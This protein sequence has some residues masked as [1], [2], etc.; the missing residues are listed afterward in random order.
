LCVFQPAFLGASAPAHGL[1]LL[2]KSGGK[3][4]MEISKA[5]MLG[6]MDVAM[7]DPV[8]TDANIRGLAE[9]IVKEGYGFA[10]IHSLHVPACQAILA[11]TKHKI[12]AC[13]GFPMGIIKTAI[14]VAET[15]C[16]LVDG[17]SEIDM[18]INLGALIGSDLEFARQDIAAVVHA[19]A[20]A[21]V[22]VIIETPYLNRDQKVLASRV[23]QDAGAA[24]V[25]T[26][27]GYSP[28]PLALYED[29]RLIRE[30]VGAAMGVKA[31]GRM[32]NYHRFISMLEAGANRVGLSLSGAR[33]T[34]RGWEAARA[35]R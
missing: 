28:D 7:L 8:T 34:V 30:T 35:Q 31:S 6:M 24:F 2:G 11:G 17:A 1:Y 29:V 27:T 9:A 23:A 12:V 10:C 33:E 13:V 3:D 22:K 25:K 16:A 20:G 14:K 18:V 4:I 19:A 15:E 26:C 32:R 5:K 21:P